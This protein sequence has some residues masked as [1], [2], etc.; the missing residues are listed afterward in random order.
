MRSCRRSCRLGR[1]ARFASSAILASRANRNRRRRL[2]CTTRTD[3]HTGRPVERTQQNRRCRMRQYRAPGTLPDPFAGSFATAVCSPA[4]GVEE[5]KRCTRARAHR[6]STGASPRKLPPHFGRSG[7]RCF[8]RADRRRFRR[9]TCIRTKHTL[10][11]R[12]GKSASCCGNL[13]TNCARSK[14]DAA[15]L[16]FQLE[17]ITKRKG[18]PRGLPLQ[19]AN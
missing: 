16:T 4:P 5:H 19:I 3:S 12:I 11:P 1:P 14:D 15:S 18:S 7:Q 9:T 17:E 13:G 10:Q 2:P 6:K 8:D